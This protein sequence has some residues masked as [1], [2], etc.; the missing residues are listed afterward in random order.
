MEAILD[1]GVLVARPSAQAARPA[2]DK[3]TLLA[4]MPRHFRQLH[5]GVAGGGNGASLG[6]VAEVRALHL[7]IGTDV[8][9]G[10][11]GWILEDQGTALAGALPRQVLLMMT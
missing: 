4:L 1:A 3:D 7:P 6:V 8:D 10:P 2:I 5:K 9:M 11:P